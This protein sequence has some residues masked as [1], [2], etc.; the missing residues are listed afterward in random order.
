MV[1]RPENNHN[2]PASHL[3]KNKSFIDEFAQSFG[4]ANVVGLMDIYASAREKVD[5][6]VNSQ[7]LRE[8]VGKYHND[9]HYCGDHKSTL[10]FLT[11]HTQ[12]NDVIVTM[13]AGDIFHLYDK[14]PEVST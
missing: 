6:T 3:F 11:K 9:S 12:K 2:F 4:N 5:P 8:A 13:G 14:L 10:K 1:C 7:K